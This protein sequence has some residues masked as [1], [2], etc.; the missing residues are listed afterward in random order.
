ME[1]VGFAFIPCSV[2]FLCIYRWLASCL[3]NL[4]MVIA[5]EF[6]LPCSF[7]FFKLIFEGTENYLLLNVHCSFHSSCLLVCLLW[8]YFL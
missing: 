8:I 1:P 4:S 2:F 3:S 5:Y 7:N 6:L